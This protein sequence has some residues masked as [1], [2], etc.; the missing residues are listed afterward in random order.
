MSKPKK[1]ETQDKKKSLVENAAIQIEQI[2][3]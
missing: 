3:R 2:D 1:L